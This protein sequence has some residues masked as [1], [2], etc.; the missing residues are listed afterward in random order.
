MN[1]EGWIQ[2]TSMLFEYRLEISDYVVVLHLADAGLGVLVPVALV[3]MTRLVVHVDTGALA[4]TVDK[5]TNVGVT[6][7]VGSS[8]LASEATRAL[9]EDLKWNPS[10]LSLINTIPGM[11]TKKQ[12]KA[13]QN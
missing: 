5:V 10:F 8:T 13:K 4:G 12:K 1:A 3:T 9:K 7:L 6:V 2:G 11:L